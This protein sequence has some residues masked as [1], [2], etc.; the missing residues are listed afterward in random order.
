MPRISRIL[1]AAAAGIFLAALQAYAQTDAI[2]AN[3]KINRGT[4]TEMSTAEVTLDMAGVARKFPVNEIA[5]IAFGE[6]PIDL[7]AARNSVD[8]KNYNSA[9][10]QLDKIDV[11]KVEKDYIKQDIAFYKAYC[12]SKLAL[13]EGGNKGDAAKAMFAV[14]KAYPSNYHFYE[15]A[16]VLG[17]L[18][19]A[20]ANFAAAADY[21][22]DKGLGSAPW[23]EYKLRA[24]L[25]MGRALV[26]AGKYDEAGKA[27]DAVTASG[28]N[29]AEAAAFKQHA[30]VGKALCLG[31]TGKADE[32]ITALNEIVAKNDPQLDGKLFARAYNALGN[33]YLEQKKPKDAL[34]AFLKTD[35][36]FFSDADAHAEALSKLAKL[37]DETGH[38]DRATD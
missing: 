24:G 8:Q 18:G 5:K 11:S 14:F 12:L 17:D 38:S 36:L 6:E 28:E 20:T 23:P 2:T 32:G 21:Y 16:E 15:M 33:C 35:L 29:N 4:I 31:S 3:K 26:L 7:T 27:F 13:T 22:G 1:A 30:A 19:V 9:R 37:W 25:A 10:D 34:M